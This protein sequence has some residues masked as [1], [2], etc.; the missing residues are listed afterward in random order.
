MDVLKPV[1]V[2]LS[3]PV[4]DKFKARVTDLVISREID[5]GDLIEIEGIEGKLAR[6]LVLFQRLYRT[7][8]G[9]EVP[10]DDLR[11]LSPRDF[12]ALDQAMRPFADI[13]PLTGEPSP[14]DSSSGGSPSTPSN[15]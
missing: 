3:R 14:E 12:R 11:H 15:A 10:L 8:E 9:N 4:V 1:K 2:T 13:G 5:V 6:T 7:V